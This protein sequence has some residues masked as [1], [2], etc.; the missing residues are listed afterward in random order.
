MKRA[1]VEAV[2]S[3]GDF[4]DAILD[5]GQRLSF[6][7]TG[8]VPVVIT[9]ETMVLDGEAADRGSTSWRPDFDPAYQEQSPYD[10]I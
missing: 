6:L 4:V 9:V 7:I 10:L 2:R 1:I 8:I 3:G 5:G